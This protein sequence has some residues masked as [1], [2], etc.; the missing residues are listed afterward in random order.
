MTD[1][2]PSERVDAGRAETGTR[3]V[4]TGLDLSM[5]DHLHDGFQIID[6]EF[7]YV[8]LN[9]AVL[10]HAR[11][12]RA[13]LLGR[14]MMEAFPGIEES[15]MFDRLRGCFETR[16]P[17]VMENVFSF[18]DGSEAVFRLSMQPLDGCVAILSTDV[19]AQRR[20]EAQLR[21]AQKLEAVGRVASGIAH[22]F[23]NVLTAVMSFTTFALQSLDDDAPAREDLDEVIRAARRAEDLTRKL[24]TFA[25]EQVD[26][27][28]F[29][30]VND[31]VREVST[32]LQRMIGEGVQMTLHLTD[33]ECP[34]RIDRGG[35]GQVLMNLVVNAR[36]AMPGGGR[37]LVETSLVHLEEDV[38]LRW[39]HPIPSGDYVVLAVSDEGTGMTP[40]VIERLFE[41]FFSTKAVGKGTG[42]GLSVC[43]GIVERAGGHMSVYSEPGRGSTFRVYLPRIDGVDEDSLLEPRPRARGGAE[44][45]AV[46][47]DDEQVARLIV[48]SLT[49][50]GYDVHPFED[51][52]A[53][54]NALSR[55]GAPDLLVTDV[56]MP[57]MSGRALATSLRKKHPEMRVLYVS[58]YSPNAAL[59]RAL[60][61]AGESLLEK[62]FTPEGIARRVREVLEA[63]SR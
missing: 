58:G 30:D 17:D 21:Q 51:P 12:D 44:T 33:E 57:R 31:L 61:D 55:R 16:K 10:G 37:L 60:I 54:L 41:P 6:R 22:D 59:Q 49:E 14:T 50:R 28:R 62:P 34:V 32:M 9:D 36:D 38:G 47:E 1:R 20:L 56:V 35:F 5:L 7:R 40:E 23:N 52:K 26:D 46:V 18:P 25:R 45:I 13:S 39:G 2:K 19:T 29:E 63:P 4:P 11:T 53:A 43:F 24:L 3:A 42:L 15:E 27:P 8:Y 48:R